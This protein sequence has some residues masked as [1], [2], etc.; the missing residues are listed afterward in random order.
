M[1]L[2]SV[3]GIILAYGIFGFG[4]ERMLCL[5]TE[6]MRSLWSSLLFGLVIG[7]SITFLT[8]GLLGISSFIMYGQ[9]C[10]FGLAGL[11]LLWKT[12]AWRSWGHLSL[13]R[14]GLLLSV[15]VLL[16]ALLLSSNLI[17]EKEG[18]LH[19]GVLNAYGDLAWHAANITAFEEGQQF[20][21]QNPIYPG[22]KLI[23]PFLSD[24]WSATLM[25]LGLSLSA[26]MIL[27]AVL[28]I[29]MFFFFVYALVSDGSVSSLG[30]K[31]SKIAGCLAIALFLFGGATLGFTRI[32]QDWKQ[33]DEPVIEFVTHLPRDYA[34]FSSDKEQYHF[35]NPVLALL[36]PQ[37]AF[38]FGFP[39]SIAICFLM[40]SADGKRRKFFYAGAGILA[41]LLP[42]FHAH[43]ALAIAPVVVLFFLA[44][45]RR[46]WMFFFIPAFALGVPEI[47][48][49]ASQQLSAQSFFHFEP[50]WTKGGEAFM[51]FWF[52]N[53]GLFMP[54]LL[55]GL[56]FRPPRALM[57]LA[58]AG[59]GWFVGGNLFVFAPWAWDNIKVLI[60]FFLFGIPLVSWLLV[61]WMVWPKYHWAI[62]MGAVAMIVFQCISGGL[63]IWRLALATN[64]TWVEWD[65][66]AI[67]VAA[68]IRQYTKPGEIIVTAPLHNTAV[69]L[70]GRYQFLGYPGH[71]WSHGLDYVPRQNILAQLYLGQVPEDLEPKP[72]YVL[73]GPAEAKH[74]TQI[75][76]PETW[77]TVFVSDG[78]TLYRIRYDST[79][80]S[81]D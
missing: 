57:I 32:A 26:S 36:L 77:E 18:A 64:E 73:V 2:I 5:A 34:G 71:I 50:G 54:L 59:I 78:Y 15:C 28:L 63:D 55:V 43:T 25:R 76:I 37:R 69:A 74:F 19:T 46:E 67:Q 80:S 42:L 24:F 41:G 8:V 27:P 68:N 52:K 39:I 38:L 11:G 65:R 79:N 58:L 81:A 13:D 72:D 7:I 12:N 51:K 47:L 70:S 20:P 30:K 33:S 3:L 62:R 21:P 29:S 10:L 40:M 75:S 35:M 48:Y 56:L 23:Y 45:P 1:A 44:R 61:R 6:K 22:E 4:V 14:V 31:Y 60:F 53:T 66:P 9:A 16:F 49:Y 17:F